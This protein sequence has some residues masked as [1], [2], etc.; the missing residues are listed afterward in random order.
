MDILDQ[1]QN[2]DKQLLFT[3]NS[4]HTPWLDRFMWL[5]SDTVVW[6]PVLLIFL[7]VLFKNKQSRAL[8][9]ILIF[10]VL[11]LIT[12]QVSSG[13]IKPLVER[14]RPTHDPEFGDWVITVNNYKG[15]QYGFVSSHAAN[16][17]GFAMLSLLLFRSW[18]YS[19]II[20]VWASMISFSRIYM[21]VH[22]PLDV[23]CGMLLGIFSAIIIFSLY[24]RFIEKPVKSRG[25]HTN[26]ERD[27]TSG[28]FKKSD[29]YFLVYSLLLLISTLAIASSSLSWK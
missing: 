18:P 2:W 8:I 27:M 23:I 10:V 3:L 22:Y 4:H 25:R 20:I 11:L 6:I 28:E 5:L 9:L 16:V 14:L 21:G 29:V 12:D 19:I 15:G 1:I 24:R 17:F 7:V 13:I 26:S